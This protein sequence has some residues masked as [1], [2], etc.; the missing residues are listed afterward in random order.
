MQACTTVAGQTRRNHSQADHHSAL[1]PTNAHGEEEQD[2]PTQQNSHLLHHIPQC[3]Q[4]S[5]T[6]STEPTGEAHRKPVRKAKVKWPKASDKQEWRS[7]DQNLYTVLQN[8]IRSSAT[9]KLNIF[10]DIIY[11]E[12]IGRFGELIQRKILPKQSGRWE[13]EI[14]QLVKERRLVRKAWRK[15]M[16]HESIRARLTN[17]RWAERIR[18][19]RSRKVL[20]LP[21]T[22]ARFKLLPGPFQV[23]PKP[24]GGE[25]ERDTAYYRT[26]TGGVHQD[27]D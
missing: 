14:L 5:K 19:R 18:K 4:W 15:A 2:Q 12:G 8:A 16:D 7:F 6:P 10:G 27:P 1:D 21:S 24:A 13:R 9:A 3:D 25:E 11:E 17:L 22:S 26:G 23:G 20:L